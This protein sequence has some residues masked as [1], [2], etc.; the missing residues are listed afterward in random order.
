MKVVPFIRTALV[1]RTREV[2]S[3]TIWQLCFRWP[4][5]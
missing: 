2:A 5:D 3:Y 4:Q 1:G